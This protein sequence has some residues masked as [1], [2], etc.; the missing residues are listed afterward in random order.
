MSTYPIFRTKHELRPDIPNARREKSRSLYLIYAS[1]FTEFRDAIQ[2]A[3][4]TFSQEQI[5]PDQCDYVIYKIS[6]VKNT[7]SHIANSAKKQGGKSF[8]YNRYSLL[9]SANYICDQVDTLTAVIREYKEITENHSAQK[10]KHR[11]I[12]NSLH[13]L[14]SSLQDLMKELDKAM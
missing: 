7:V 13:D 3:K 1:Q 6:P 12:A 4:E 14:T 2:E 5:W 11:L 9:A 8:N 10:S